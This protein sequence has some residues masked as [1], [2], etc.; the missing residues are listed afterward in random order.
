MKIITNE[1]IIIEEIVK[2]GLQSLIGLSEDEIIEEIYDIV[3]CSSGGVGL[4]LA[5]HVLDNAD[6]K[7]IIF[8]VKDL[9]NRK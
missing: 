8:K 2:P 4:D 3:R 1:R 7:V 9:I 5:L 6:W